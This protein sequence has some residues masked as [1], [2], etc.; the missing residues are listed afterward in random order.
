MRKFIVLVCLALCGCAGMNTVD[1]S[2]EISN[3]GKSPVVNVTYTY[4]VL[5]T[6]PIARLGLGGGGVTAPMEVPETIQVTWTTELDG[7]RHSVTVP[8]KSALRQSLEGKIVSIEIDG[9]TIHVF[10]EQRNRDFTRSKAL[11]Y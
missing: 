3:T 1:H 8:L 7:K 11:F 2:V 4:G 10:I 6:R 9:G 5:G